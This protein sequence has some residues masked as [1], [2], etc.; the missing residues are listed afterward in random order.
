MAML[1]SSEISLDLGRGQER[2]RV[3]SRVEK[4]RGVEEM[5]VG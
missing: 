5:R 2:R 1:D 4:S 3:E